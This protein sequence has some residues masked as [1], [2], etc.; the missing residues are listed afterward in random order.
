MSPQTDGPAAQPPA[1]QTAR[2]QTRKAGSAQN[3]GA[4]AA[5]LREASSLPE[6]LAVSFEAFEAIRVLARRSED[7]VPGLFA[8]FMMAADAA[9]DGKEAVTI[10]PSLSPSPSG[11]LPTGLPSADAGIKTI[12]DGIA[13]LGVLLDE[14]LTDAAHRARMPGD[15]AA[16]EE[17]AGAGRR[18]Y[19]LMARDGD[20]RRL[21]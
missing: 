7:A 8:A 5:R 19:Q 4:I 18:I 9:V 1:P 13:A 16:C 11:T 20:D 17:A 21:R 10:A 3:A 15:R 14:R 6:L 2:S 12:A